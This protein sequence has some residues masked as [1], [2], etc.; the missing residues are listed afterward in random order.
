MKKNI[1]VPQFNNTYELLPEDIKDNENLIFK[2]VQSDCYKDELTSLQSNREI[3]KTSSDR[4][5]L[6]GI[7][8]GPPKFW[9]Y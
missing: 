4:L 2:K 6:F 3:S 7:N 1:Q 5:F 9:T 8:N